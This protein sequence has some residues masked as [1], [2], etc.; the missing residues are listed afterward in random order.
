MST[1]G[2]YLS[3]VRAPEGTG[4]YFRREYLDI[5]FVPSISIDRTCAV[6]NEN[7]FDVN[8]Y[9]LLTLVHGSSV[10]S[11]LNY[12]GLMIPAVKLRA[13]MQLKFLYDKF[14]PHFYSIWSKV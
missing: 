8:M 11:V 13:T 2:W 7:G 9:E 3:T 10:E 14:S 1:C 5:N 4:R 6:M 12:F